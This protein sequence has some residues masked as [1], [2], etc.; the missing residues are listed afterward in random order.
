[1]N[2]LVSGAASGI[3]MAFVR[4]LLEKGHKVFAV[5]VLPIDRAD[6][7]SFVADVR[8]EEDMA[9]IYAALET[10]GVVLDAIVNVA[11]VHTMASLVESDF[12]QMKRV[13]DVN[14]LGAMLF[15]KTFHP[16]LS[17]QGRIVIVS[18]EV[19]PLD[20]MPFNGLYSL[21]KTALDSYAQALRQ[22]LNLIGQK[23]VTVRP[24]AIETPLCRSSLSATETLASETRL[25]SSQA[26]RFLGLTKRFMGKPMSAD[27][28]AKILVKATVKKH[29]RLIYKKHHNPGLVLLSILPKRLQ[30]ALI[31]LLLNR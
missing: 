24:G 17:K 30:C 29:P 26:D 10:D 25:Y 14:L 8:S 27:R 20:P 5:D 12:A 16:L 19:A 4:A 13:I 31:K 28:F 15:N 21:S 18:S 2:I 9:E 6:V 22:E 11:G 1:M 7:R 3:G 23:V